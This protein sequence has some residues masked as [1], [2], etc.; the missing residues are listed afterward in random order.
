M[1]NQMEDRMRL[2]VDSQKTIAQFPMGHTQ[3]LHT[4]YQGKL[5]GFRGIS[6]SIRSTDFALQHAQDGRPPHCFE[7]EFI[8]VL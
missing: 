5:L 2:Y 1:L 8:L 3:E 6:I 7:N 4:R